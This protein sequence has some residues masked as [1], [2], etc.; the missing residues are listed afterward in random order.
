[1]VRH[2][3]SNLCVNKLQLNLKDIPNR[4]ARVKDTVLASL[5]FISIL[6]LNVTFSRFV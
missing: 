4:S 2:V 1:M 6:Y 5:F 3:E